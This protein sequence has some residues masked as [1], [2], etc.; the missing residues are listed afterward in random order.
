MT[1][2]G[3]FGAEPQGVADEQILVETLPGI[4]IEIDVGAEAALVQADSQLV[5]QLANRL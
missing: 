2:I 5:F 1:A 3:R 4:E